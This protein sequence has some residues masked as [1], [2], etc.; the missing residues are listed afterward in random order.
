MATIAV[1]SQNPR[2]NGTILAG[3]SVLA[4]FS[5]LAVR[6]LS[7]SSCFFHDSAEQVVR[8]LPVTSI[9]EMLA[10]W[11]PGGGQLVAW[12]PWMN[13]AESAIRLLCRAL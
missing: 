11:L 8:A 6:T 5:Q 12:C 2:N 3:F 9:C 4:V 1:K 10:C 13:L 7:E